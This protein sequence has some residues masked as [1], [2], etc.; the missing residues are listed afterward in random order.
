MSAP[1]TERP[2]E[3]GPGAVIRERYRLDRIIGRGGLGIVYAGTDLRTDQTVAIKILDGVD[4]RMQA[5]MIREA[6]LLRSLYG[7]GDPGIATIVDLVVEEGRLFLIQQYVDG[8]PLRRWQEHRPSLEVL[9]LYHSVAVSLDRVH[10]LHVVHRDLKPENILVS[11]QR[12]VIIDF[13]LAIRSTEADQLTRTGMMV[14]TPVYLSPEAIRGDEI[15][16]H[17]DVFSL[18]VMLFEAVAG[19]PPWHADSISVALMSR[20]QSPPDLEKLGPFEPR[21]GSLLRA[22]LAVEAARRPTAKQVAEVLGRVDAA[23]SNLDNITLPI[24]EPV[25]SPS[26]EFSI[27]RANADR[28]FAPAPAPSPA[29]RSRRML[30]RISGTAAL[31]VLL[32]WLGGTIGVFSWARGTLILALWLTVMAAGLFLI[33]RTRLLSSRRR[34]ARDLGMSAGVIERVAAIEESV[35]KTSELTQTLAVAINDLG[36]RVDPERLG[37]LIRNT[38]VLAL[39]GMGNQFVP[40]TTTTDRALEVIRDLTRAREEKKRGLLE[41]IAGNAGAIGGI[42]T[43]IAA[44]VGLMATMNVW[45]PNAAP[46][47]TAFALDRARI[48]PGGTYMLSVTA[49]DPEAR[50]LTYAF[51]ASTGVIEG[52]GPS[53]SW[54]PPRPLTDT[55]VSFTVSVSDGSSPVMK[56]ISVRVNVRPAGQLNIES[57]VPRNS[58]M[59]LIA[60][61]NDPDGD[62]LTFRWTVTAGV[63]PSPQRVTVWTT[64]QRPGPVTITCEVNDG[65]ES[66]VL[67]KTVMVK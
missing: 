26:S 9:R 48:T 28:E 38:V 13:G 58:Q 55:L 60:D 62:S 40:Q 57:T 37:D 27:E 6:R 45:K 15:D 7:L 53:A 2:D 16:T 12:P 22:M 33:G 8:V 1:T 20:L 18:G 29:S 25:V 34:A 54:T 5:V 3:F 21:L 51:T 63:D 59:R 67:E 41:R 17:A 64:P 39:Q 46:T 66:A 19:E 14:G 4:D 31:L 42:V 32:A 52:A 50:A 35:K 11:G 49:N 61:V 47:I 65:F 36:S 24:L 10:S 44:I 30:A 43:V 56:Q 23:H